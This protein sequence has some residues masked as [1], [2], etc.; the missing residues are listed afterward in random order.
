MPSPNQEIIVSENKKALYR[1]FE[2]LKEKG[3]ACPK[4]Q[5]ICSA[6]AITGLDK[7]Y[8]LGLED[9]RAEKEEEYRAFLVKP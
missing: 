6:C 8:Q 7:A 3:A 2:W 9:G 5:E 1:I 4:D